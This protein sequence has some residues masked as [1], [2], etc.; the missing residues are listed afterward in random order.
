MN[1]RDFIKGSVKLLAAIPALALLKPEAVEAKSVDYSPSL[2]YIDASKEIFRGISD[3]LEASGKDLL[4]ATR[5]VVEAM[6]GQQVRWNGAGDS[7]ESVDGGKT[8]N[9]TG[10]RPTLEIQPDGALYVSGDFLT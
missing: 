4:E 8:W 3:G 1:R 6:A 5:P 7:W 2:D 10:F 9:Q